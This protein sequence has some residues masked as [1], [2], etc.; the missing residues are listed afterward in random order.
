MRAAQGSRPAGSRAPR[1]AARGPRG[2]SLPGLPPR[3]GR[4]RGPGRCRLPV[5]PLSF[6]LLLCQPC[7]RDRDQA[8][9]AAVAQAV[10]TQASD[11]TL[12]LGRGRRVHRRRGGADLPCPAEAKAV[13]TYWQ[14]RRAAAR[15]EPA[16]DGSPVAVAG[17]AADDAGQCPHARRPRPDAAAACRIQGTRAPGSRSRTPGTGPTSTPGSSPRCAG[18][19]FRGGAVRHAAAAAPD[20]RPVLAVD[21]ERAELEEQLPGSPTVCATR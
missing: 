21:A 14:A 10:H 7:I 18:R 9:L 17:A 15:T 8:D 5:R 4:V 20:S 3:R 19:W 16:P 11:G 2:L 13:Y 1:A 12:L 6:P